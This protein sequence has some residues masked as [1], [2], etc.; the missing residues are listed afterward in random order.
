MAT[1][2]LPFHGDTSALIFKAILDS[3]PPPAIRFNREIPPSFERH[4]QPRPRKGHGSCAFKARSRNAGRAAAAQ[5]GQQ[6]Q[7][8]WRPVVRGRCAVARESRQQAAATPPARLNPVPAPVLD[9]FD[10]IARTGEG[11]EIRVTGK[12]NL[13]KVLV[14]AFAG[15]LVVRWLPERSIIASA[16]LRGS[17]KK[18][19][20]FSPTSPT[21]RATRYSTTR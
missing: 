19:Q 14:P 2:V 7:G 12:R 21:A 4:H 10:R 16:G 1:G 3:D 5:A 20:S 18:T 11:T 15:G 17:R 9:W 13:W 8:G 6:R